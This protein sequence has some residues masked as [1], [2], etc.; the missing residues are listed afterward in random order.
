MYNLEG[1]VIKTHNLSLQKI[2][3][4]CMKIQC[5]RMYHNY[6]KEKNVEAT[7]SHNVKK[8]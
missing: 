1:K 2:R 5:Y 3:I 8:T 7:C 6:Q 4:S